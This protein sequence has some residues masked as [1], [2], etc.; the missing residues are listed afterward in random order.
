MNGSFLDNLGRVYGLYTGGFLVFI[1]LMAVLEQMGV[2]ADTIGILF[3]SFTIFIY[4][5]IGW[6]SRTMEVEAYYVMRPPGAR[7]L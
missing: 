3:V 7:R 1:L 4:A 6:L 5:A 2:G